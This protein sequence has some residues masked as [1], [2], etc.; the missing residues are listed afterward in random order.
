[1]S[2]KKSS[3][4]ITPASGSKKLIP[5][6]DLTSEINGLR[7]KPIHYSPFSIYPLLKRNFLYF[8]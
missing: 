7:L 8:S 6:V 4:T 2:G 3:L 5:L 1:M